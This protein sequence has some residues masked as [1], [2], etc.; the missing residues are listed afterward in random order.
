M[1]DTRSLG[2]GRENL[3][4]A[5]MLESVHGLNGRFLDLAAAGAAR[6][7][8]GDWNPEARLGL[9]AGVSARLSPLSAAQKAA[10]ATCPYA[11]FDLRFRD[12]DFWRTALE[13]GG[14]WIVADEQRVSPDVIDFVRLALFFAWHVATT[15]RLAAEWLLGMNDGTLTTFRAATIDSLPDRAATAAVHLTAR[16]STCPAYW[17]ALAG[18]AAH[19]DPAGLRKV[20]LYGLQ[21]AAAARLA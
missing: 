20:Q 13:S 8:A 19:P 2:W 1:R 5:G 10:A 18:A 7:S 21:L 14:R 12:D 6:M 15:G 11:L 9:P 16:W 17:G 3:I 4:S